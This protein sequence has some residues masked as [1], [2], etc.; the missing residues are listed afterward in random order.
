MTEEETL[1]YLA[2]D[3]EKLRKPFKRSMQDKKI[4]QNASFNSML[5][6]AK[7]KKKLVEFVDEEITS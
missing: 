5:E 2:S 3:E 1:D 6:T 4:L 7:G